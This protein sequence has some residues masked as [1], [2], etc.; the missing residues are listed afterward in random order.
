M[1]REAGI[2]TSLD[3][4]ARPHSSEFDQASAEREQ[5]HL[6]ERHPGKSGWN[7]FKEGSGKEFF[8]TVSPLEGP[9]VS[10][11]GVLP[12]LLLCEMPR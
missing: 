8:P 4:P 6:E 12:T 1:I 7:L 11:Q 9:K 5:R 10:Q 3:W 2:P